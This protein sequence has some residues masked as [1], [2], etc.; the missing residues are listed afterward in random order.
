MRDL[1]EYD[2]AIWELYLNPKFV[3]PFLVLPRTPSSTKQHCTP[4]LSYQTCLRVILL[5]TLRLSLQLFAPGSQLT[6]LKQMVCVT[7]MSRVLLPLANSDSYSSRG[8]TEEGK[9]DSC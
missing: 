8:S 1:V 2:C 6:K 7:G 3:L 4:I 9:V 5:Q